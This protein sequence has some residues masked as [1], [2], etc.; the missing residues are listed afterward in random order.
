MSSIAQGESRK[1]S[2]RVKW[3]HKRQMEKGVVFGACPFGYNLYKGKLTV[4]EDEAKIVKLIF[5]LYLSG[6]GLML[7]S[8]ELANRGI[9]SPNGAERWKPTVIRQVLRN[10]KYIGV[11][12]QR[13]FITTDYL[14]HKR[15]PNEGEEAVITVENSH[16]PIIEP[17]MFDRVQK[18]M[19]RRKTATIEKSR[20]SNRH[21]WSSKVKCAYCNSTFKRRINNRKMQNSQIIWQCTEA[22]KFGREKVNAQG[23]KV[24]CNC[25]AIHEQILKEN[26]LAVLNTVIENKDQVIQELKNSVQKVIDKSPNNAPEIKVISTDMEK[27]AMRKVKLL[28]LCVDGLITRAEFEK[29]NNQY[30]KQ[31][32]ALNKQLLALKLDNKVAEDLQQKLEDIEKTIETIVRLK[33]FSESVC[34]EILHKVVVEGR[35]KMSFCLTTGENKDPVFINM[36]PLLSKY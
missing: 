14:S 26:F 15:K 6:L 23:K 19:L 30:N 8:K 1:I 16:E 27:I 20:Y 7:V 32:E 2:E 36:S 11:L 29:S 31:I 5:D 22:L 28:D 21:V 18:E 33:E 34:G 10:E 3:G 25:R 17:E 12:K 9:S 24:G 4:N 13:K 35:D